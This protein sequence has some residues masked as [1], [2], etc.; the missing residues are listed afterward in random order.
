MI[1]I[2]QVA[3][4]IYGILLI[5]GGIIGKAKSG[6]SASLFAGAIC[7]I[8][9]LVGYWQSLSD[10][11][12]G[13]LTG[14]LVGLLLTGIFMSRFVRTRKFMPAGLVLLLSLLVG[15]LTMMARTGIP[16]QPGQTSARTDKKGPGT[17]SLAQRL[18]GHSLKIR[19]SP[20]S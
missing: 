14:G 4:A 20:P 10:P 19:R 6:S 15:I 1:E 9:A 3:L 13:F 5:V 2:A 11:A 18:K 17:I 8:A 7:G 16:A 12:I